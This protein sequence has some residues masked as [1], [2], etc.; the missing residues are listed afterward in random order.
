MKEN[1]YLSEIQSKQDQST[2]FQSAGNDFAALDLNLQE[3]LVTHPNSTF[4]FRL[5]N[6]LTSKDFSDLNLKDKLLVIDKSL[7]PQATDLVIAFLDGELCVIN[8]QKLRGKV[9]TSET[10]P[11]I[12]GVVS[13]IIYC[14]R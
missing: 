1:Y 14:L 5:D 13:S 4:F 9:Q 10:A 7:I 3:Q 11:E 6:Q 2:G 8:F 12:W